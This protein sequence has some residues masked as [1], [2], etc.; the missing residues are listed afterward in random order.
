MSMKAILFDVDGVLN[1]VGSELFSQ[2]YARERGIDPELLV[3]FFRTEWAEVVTGKKDAAEAIEAH[4]HAWQWEGDLD[5]LFT[6]WFESENHPDQDALAIV[7][8]LRERGVKCYITTNQEKNRGK[9]IKDVMFPDLFDGYFISS[10]MGV[11]K[12]DPEYFTHVIN[13]IN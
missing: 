8:Q 1:N 6:M 13:A 3:N 10:E 12:P 5:D 11:K 7:T 2:K 9:Y 4:R